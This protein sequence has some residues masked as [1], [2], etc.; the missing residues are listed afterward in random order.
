MSVGRP[1]QRQSANVMHSAVCEYVNR[2]RELSCCTC[3]KPRT[4]A[5][6]RHIIC[7]RRKVHRVTVGHEEPERA[8]IGTD[9]IQHRVAAVQVDAGGSGGGIGVPQGAAG[10]VAAELQALGLCGLTWTT[11]TEARGPDIRYSVEQHRNMA[12]MEHS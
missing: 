10:A 1:P 11:T 7:P 12:N 6:E 5:P 9:A 3:M 4:H 2:C 8:S